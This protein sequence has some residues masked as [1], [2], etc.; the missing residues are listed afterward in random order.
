MQKLVVIYKA[1]RSKEGAGA[2]AGHT[3]SMAGS[4]GQFAELIDMAG[5]V[6]AETAD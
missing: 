2:V 3:A 1:G 6:V 4:Y 5:A